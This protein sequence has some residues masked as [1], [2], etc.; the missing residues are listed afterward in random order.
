MHIAIEGIDGVGKTTLARKLAKDIGFH[1]IE[2]HLHALTDGDDIDDI[3]NY[4]RITSHVNASD[5]ATFRAW[6]YALGNLYLKE[7]YQNTNIVTDRYFASNYSWN[8]TPENEF[9]FEKLMELLGKP[10]IT[11]LI[12]ANP[13]VRAERIRRRNPNDPDLLN[14]SIDFSERMYGKITSFLQK[15]SFNYYLIDTSDMTLE[16]SL[17]AIRQ[18]LFH[19]FPNIFLQKCENFSEK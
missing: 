5:N 18:I 12:Y 9:I 7:H 17:Q 11:F 15:Y 14:S 2:K 13:G 4:M 16:D 1:C 6:F 8:G 3:P 19:E 10:D